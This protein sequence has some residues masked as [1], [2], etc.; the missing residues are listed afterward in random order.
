[1]NLLEKSVWRRVI[2][3]KPAEGFE[4]QNYTPQKFP[5]RMPASERNGVK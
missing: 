1:M 5:N 2:Q 3:K 4:K